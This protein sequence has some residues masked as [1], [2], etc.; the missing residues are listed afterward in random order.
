MNLKILTNLAALSLL[1]TA[2]SAQG[3]YSGPEYGGYQ[4]HDDGYSTYGY[5]T[6][7]YEPSIVGPAY[8]GGPWGYGFDDTYG[9]DGWSDYELPPPAQNPA[10]PSKT[11]EI[12]QDQGK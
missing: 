2:V 5:P 8:V 7:G 11:I 10:G 12:P 4:G 9:L 6:Y 1:V 3:S